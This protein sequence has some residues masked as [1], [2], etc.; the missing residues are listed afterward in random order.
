MAEVVNDARA[1]RAGTTAEVAV[2]GAGI[3]GLSCARSLLDFGI[4][5]AVFE[6]SRGLG[7]RAT[8]RRVGDRWFDHGAPSLTARDPRFV[9]LVEEWLEAGRVQEWHTAVEV[10]RPLQPKAGDQRLV[11]V[12]GM[13]TLGHLVGA[14]VPCQLETRITAVAQRGSAWVLKAEDGR[15]FGPFAG[16]VAAVPAPQA[17]PL[18]TVA[19]RLADRAALVEFAPCWTV[20]VEFAA[21]VALAPGSRPPRGQ[22]LAWAVHEASRPGRPPGERWVLHA[23]GLWTVAHINDAP[24]A[25]AAALLGAFAGHLAAPL[26][27]TAFTATHRWLHAVA[28][29]PLRADCLWDAWTRI[30]ACG[31]WCATGDI[32]GAW[33]SGRAL[34]LLVRAT[35]R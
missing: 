32:E 22:S 1:S 5:C 12:P 19:P 34:A 17:A 16:V 29:Y 33:R 18:L 20:M 13:S 2:I 14:G 8:T 26:P 7:G 25:V 23:N 35:L 9:A 31:D 27:A 10:G 11:A 30:G 21:P 3:A 28:K 6:K 15:S 24:E 4:P